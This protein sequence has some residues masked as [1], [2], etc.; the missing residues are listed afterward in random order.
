MHIDFDCF[1][2][3]V[4]VLSRPH[5]AGKPVAVCHGQS[6]FDRKE[7]G[8]SSDSFNSRSEVASCNYVARKKGLKNGIHAILICT[9][10]RYP[11]YIL[12]IQFVLS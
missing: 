12:M 1:F 4:G 11:R 7:G 6:G 5:L 10:N 3:S 8:H 9:F 2:V